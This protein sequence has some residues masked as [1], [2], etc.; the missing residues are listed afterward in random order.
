M[1]VIS[2]ASFLKSFVNTGI[3]S[4]M[5]AH[6]KGL[7]VSTDGVTLKLPSTRILFPGIRKRVNL[8]ETLEHLAEQLKPFSPMHGTRPCVLVIDEAQELKD[9]ALQEPKV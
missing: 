8:S 9:L 4:N 2:E 3:K 5:K 7:K 1:D 6:F